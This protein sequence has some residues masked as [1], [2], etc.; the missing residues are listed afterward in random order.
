MFV[1]DVPFLHVTH[2]TIQ[3]DEPSQELK[4]KV[5]EVF[6]CLIK[7]NLS[8][9]DC[10]KKDLLKIRPRRDGRRGRKPPKQIA[11]VKTKGLKKK[12]K[13]RNNKHGMD[14]VLEKIQRLCVSK[15]D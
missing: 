4:A 11:V 13:I 2:Q 14:Q 3:F 12:K 9:F 1:K 10:T 8:K 7:A 15:Q 6:S 5:A